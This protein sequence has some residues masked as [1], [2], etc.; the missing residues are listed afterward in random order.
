MDEIYVN[1]QART[2]QIVL[3]EI[4]KKTPPPP[5]PD[6]EILDERYEVYFLLDREWA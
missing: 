4:R 1:K 3:K 6:P 2:I 5:P